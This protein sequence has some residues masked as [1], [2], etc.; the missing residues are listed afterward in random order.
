MFGL[1]LKALVTSAS[2][3]RDFI[4]GDF[5]KR[6]PIIVLGIPSPSPCA[7]VNG[8]PGFGDKSFVL[9]YKIKGFYCIIA[10]HA[11]VFIRISCFK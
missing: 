4:K 3:P 1:K 7:A 11:L 5:G 10:S 6:A 9:I 8:S 2:W